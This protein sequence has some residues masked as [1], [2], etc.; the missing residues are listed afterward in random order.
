LADLLN[1]ATQCQFCAGVH[2]VVR[3]VPAWQQPCP[4][5]KR[6]EFH[7]SGQPSAIEFWPLDSGWDANVVF[8]HQLAEDEEAEDA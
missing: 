8:P 2:D 3:G 4:R 5:I 6:I 7:E 1:G